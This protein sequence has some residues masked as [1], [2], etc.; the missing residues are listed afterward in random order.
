MATIRLKTLRCSQSIQ[1]VKHGHKFEPHVIHTVTTRSHGRHMAKTE[2]CCLIRARQGRA[3]KGN[4]HAI[5]NKTMTCLNR[6]EQHWMDNKYG[7][8][9]NSSQ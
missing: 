7:I 5:D 3:F 2:A 1:A 9:S 8:G 4:C 6:K